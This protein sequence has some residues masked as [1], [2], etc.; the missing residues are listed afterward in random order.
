MASA[1]LQTDNQSAKTY[2]FVVVGGGV[3]GLY[4]CNELIKKSRSGALNIKSILLLEASDRF[5]G[6]IE[7]WSLLR[8]DEQNGKATGFEDTWD[9]CSWDFTQP[10]RNPLAPEGNKKSPFL[11]PQE[12]FARIDEKGNVK[13]REVEYF[14]A[15]FGPMRIEP[16]DQPLL[17]ALLDELGIREQVP[18][19]K[20][21]LDDLIPFS[22]YA[23]EE[24]PEPRFTLQ[25]EEANQETPLD[26]MILALRRILE[27][28]DL[29]NMEAPWE[30]SDA[31]EQ[32]RNL[33]DDAFFYRHYWKGELLEWIHNL[34]EADFCKIREH[35]CFRGQPLWNLGFWNVLSDVLSHFAVVKIR[36]WGSYYHFVHENLNAA[37]WI[38]FWLRAIRSTG[39]LRG[40]RGGMS[41]AIWKLLEKL[42]AEENRALLTIRKGAKVSGLRSYGNTVEVIVDQSDEVIRARKVILALPK[43]PLQE[44]SWNG[45]GAPKKLQEALN[46][47]VGLPLLKCFFVI[48]KPWWEDNRPLNRNAADLPTRELLYMKSD[49]RTKGLIMIYTDRPAITFWSDY[50]RMEPTQDASGQKLEGPQIEYQETARTWFLKKFPAPFTQGKPPPIN[51]PALVK[52]PGSPRLWQRFVQFARDY[53]HHDFTK[54]RLLACGMRD[55]GKKPFGAA[56]HG[57]LPGIMPWKHMEFLEAFSLDEDSPEMNIHICGEAFSDYQGFIEGSLRSAKR[58]LNRIAP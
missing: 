17:Q 57:W 42:Y 43:R 37:E 14:R 25:G 16:R 44:L 35:A 9:P 11:G 58:V 3:A 20:P 54:D 49:D 23:S 52:E 38:I 33:H 51:S 10:D 2:D 31:N 22:S 39:S 28:V 19:A 53:G 6:R 56:A 40:I 4:C 30:T 18:G 8:S 27:L 45:T 41:R 1:D 5:G 55:W 29:D 36:D 13:T 24:P 15:E 48:E 46:G 32:W 34:T 47:V 12:T 26:L 7:T 21:S 50:L